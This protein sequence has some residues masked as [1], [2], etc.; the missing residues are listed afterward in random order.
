M[1]RHINDV[2]LR[3]IKTFEGSRLVVYRDSVGIPTVGYGHVVLQHDNLH[4]GDH[5]TKQRAAD[6]LRSDLHTAEHAVEQMVTSALTDNQFAALVSFVFNVGAGNLAKSTLL[7]RLNQGRYV[8]A[9]N[10]FKLWVKARG[11]VLPGLIRRREAER[12]LFLAA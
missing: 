11:Q 4:V 12:Q 8:D 6:F 9:S 2:G 3:L 1:T 7:K 10:Q 5:I